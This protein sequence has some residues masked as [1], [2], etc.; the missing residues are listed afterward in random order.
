M[1][2]V[3]FIRVKLKPQAECQRRDC[4]WGV[5]EGRFTGTARAAAQQHVKDTGHIVDVEIKDVTEYSP[6]ATS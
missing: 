5:I 1:K 3:T 2:G 4:G 6:D